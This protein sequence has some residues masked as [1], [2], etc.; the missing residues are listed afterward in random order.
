MQPDRRLV[1]DVH[2][3]DE[4][5]PDLAREPDALRLA[6][7]QGFGAAVERQ[8]V[9]A[10][11][12]QEGEAVGDLAHE[13]RRD[14]AAPA[15]DPHTCEEAAR[16]RDRHR[17]DLRQRVTRDEDVARRAIQPAAAA[18]HARPHAAVLGEFLA[19][20]RRFGFAIAALEVRQDAFPRVRTLR[21]RAFRVDVAELDLLLAAAPEQRVAHGLG[22]VVPGRLDVEPEMT[23]QRLDQLEVVRV[24]PVPTA[25]RATREREAGVDDHARR[26][27]ELLLAQAAA[28]AARAIGI[29]EREQPRLEFGQ[30]VAAD[31]ASETV[32]EHERLALGFVVECEACGSLCQVQ[33]RLERFRQPLLRIRPHLEPVDD[34]LDRVAAPAVELGQHI[35]FEQ[36]AV[37]A[38][39]HEPLAAQVLEHFD[40]FT[41]A[42]VHDRREQQHARVLRQRQ[43]L[44]DHLRDG[45]RREVLPV[46]GAARHACARIQHA[47]VVVDLGDGAHGR[48]RIVRRRFLFDRDRGGQALDVVDVGFLHHRE[49]LPRIGGERLD[50]AALAFRID[51][52]ERERR[53]ARARQPGD[54][55]QAVAGQVEVDVAQVVGACAADPDD[56]H[57]AR[58][59]MLW[60]GSLLI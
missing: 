10:H 56:V 18:I 23:G 36:P 15:L 5:R 47:Q 21:G 11:V 17:R 13:P 38:R 33:R 27:E 40:V 12:A 1:E 55:D 19:H 50:V 52:V 45:L 51:G 30:A 20:R 57:F 25:H 34:G 3:A 6:A 24:A 41:F 54:H 49:K 53:L 37:D 26:I 48:A 44:V 46:F 7:R 43:H 22:Q 2:H 60:K 8:V 35:E 16:L 59:Y 32:R 31:R 58:G 28:R 4:A 14:L 39:A 42:V 29:V 9:E